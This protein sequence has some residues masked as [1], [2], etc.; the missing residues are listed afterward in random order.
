MWSWATAFSNYWRAEEEEK[1]MKEIR[2][3]VKDE[4]RWRGLNAKV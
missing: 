1:K 3:A 4:G 2:R